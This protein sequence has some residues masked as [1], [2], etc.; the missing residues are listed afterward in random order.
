MS[1]LGDSQFLPASHDRSY[2]ACPAD[3]KGRMG[4]GVSDVASRGMTVVVLGS[5]RLPGLPSARFPS[6]GTGGLPFWAI[7]PPRNHALGL[8]LG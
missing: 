2:R 4:S 7:N 8:W 5:A 3:P 1:V 6:F